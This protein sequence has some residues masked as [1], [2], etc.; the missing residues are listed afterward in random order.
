MTISYAHFCADI[1]FLQEHNKPFANA[2]DNPPYL[3]LA[4]ATRFSD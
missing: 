4:V 2:R 1:V 3:K